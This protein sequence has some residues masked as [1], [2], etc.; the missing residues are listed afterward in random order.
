MVK[1]KACSI[2]VGAVGLGE[3]FVARRIRANRDNFLKRFDID[4]Y[5][6]MIRRREHTD[7]GWLAEQNGKWMESAVLAAA[8]AGDEALENKA[9]GVF[10]AV[11]ATQEPGGYVGVTPKAVRTPDKPLRGMDPYE[12]YFLLHAFLTAHEQWGDAPALAA[13]RKLGDYFVEHIGPGKAEFWPSPYRPPENVRTIVCEQYTW[14]PEGTPRAPTLHVCSEI[15]GH[16]AHYSWEGTLLI[17]PM[18]RLFQAT[19]DGRYLD[20][21]RWVID[22]ID[23]W[24]GWDSFSRLDLVAAGELGVHQLQPYVHAHTFHMNFLGFLRMYEITGEASYLHKVVGA[25]ADIAARQLYI[26]GGVSV[27]E[28][29]EPGPFK[30]VTGAV[31]ETCANMSWLELNQS[32]LELTGQ[33]RYADLIETLLWNHVFAAQAVDGDGYCYH[34]PPNGQKPRG[35]F[36]DP[37]CCTSSGHRMVSRL[38]SVIYAVGEGRLYVNQFVPSRA[39]ARIGKALVR[40]SQETNYPQD[41]RVTIRL[42]ADRPVGFALCVRL[43]AWC[44]SPAAV[45]NGQALTDLKPGTYLVLEGPW[46]TVN[47]LELTFPMQFRWQAS[48]GGECQPPATGAD[49]RWALVRGPVVYAADTVLADG[50]DEALDPGVD[51]AV[52]PSDTPAYARV[53]L[54]AGALGPGVSVP[55]VAGDGRSTMLTFWPF[56]NVGS[57]Y[58]PGGPQ[59]ARAAAFRY[60]AWLMGKDNS[61]G[62]NP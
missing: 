28:H 4:R 50:P 39:Q 59:P 52:V 44:E 56:A 61:A 30:P 31:V 29:Y 17:D 36:G 33:P 26:T 15:A 47:A 55:V 42:E 23:R 57:W 21:S 43:P 8:G 40:V 2:P 51:V 13:A 14:V 1:R 53:D 45:L 20:W 9:R 6:E 48:D 10:A 5:V 11:I 7:W 58:R 49:R 41:D 24:S 35:Y 62:R 12:L 38:P 34:T 32:L 25:H 46:K 18:L 54:P 3:G 22:N 60:A 19:G 37:C 16:T 27:G